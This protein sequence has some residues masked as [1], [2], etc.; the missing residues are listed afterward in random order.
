MSR[1]HSELCDGHK[2]RRHS[3]ARPLLAIFCAIIGWNSYAQEPRL[4][5]PALIER[6]QSDILEGCKEQG[7]RRAAAAARVNA[8]CECMYEILMRDL[9]Q[10]AWE[11]AYAKSQQTAGRN[12]GEVIAPHMKKIKA[13]WDR[14][15]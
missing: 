4:T 7:R 9:D 8:F 13:C 2:K 10:S 5:T 15:I 1:R 11:Q 14:R 12:T 3:I 6:Y